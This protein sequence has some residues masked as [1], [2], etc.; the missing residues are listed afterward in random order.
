MQQPFIEQWKTFNQVSL[1]IVQSLSEANKLAFN[2]LLQS[3]WDLATWGKLAKSLLDSANAVTDITTSSFNQAFQ[4][5]LRKQELDIV[6]SSVQEFGEIVTSLTT[7]ITQL[8]VAAFNIFI[9][10]YANNLASSKNVTSAEDAITAQI[11]LQAEIQDKL[12]SNVLDTLQTL[13]SVKS[14]LT[15]W[16]ERSIDK[17]ANEKTA[18]A[19]PDVSSG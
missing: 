5:E 3:Q 6:A 19:V 9:G 16:I 11:H 14:A 10:A 7:S 15:A 2:T 8:Q 13:A 17:M 12:K 18:A 4:N 1:D